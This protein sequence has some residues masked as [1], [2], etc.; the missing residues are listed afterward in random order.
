MD[1]IEDLLEAA[2]RAGREAM[3]EIEP[4]LRSALGLGLD[5]QDLNAAQMAVRAFVVYIVTVIVVRIGKKRFMGRATAFDVLLGIM[6]GSV[7][8]R[9]ITGNAPF[10]PALAAAAVLVFMH[11]LFSWIALRWHGFGVMVKGH[12]RVM[13]RDG[14]PDRRR[15]R[16]A[17][18]TERDLWEDLRAKGVS[19]LED[20][21]EARLE[22]SGNLSVI[23]ARG[24]PRIVDIRVA[25]GVQTVRVELG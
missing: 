20:V 8:S 25:D 9:A 7:V 10:F 5:D 11:S 12:S 3:R 4:W 16:Q 23:K 17:H 15:L 19:R 22:R 18:M 14:K 24:E 13:I 2:L 1:G 6:L 21:A